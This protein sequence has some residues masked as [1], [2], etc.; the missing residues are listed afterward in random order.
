MLE[1]RSRLGIIRV[2][3][4]HWRSIA[5]VFERDLHCAGRALACP[6]FLLKFIRG[7]RA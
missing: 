3:A 5:A 1:S 4:D 6:H 2:M 7:Q